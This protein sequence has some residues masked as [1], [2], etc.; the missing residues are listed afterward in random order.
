MKWNLRLTAANRDIRK[1]S[2]L[3]RDLA[4]KGLVTSAGKM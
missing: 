3:Q 2:E 4:E 1:A